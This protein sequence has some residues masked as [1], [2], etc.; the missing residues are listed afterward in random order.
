MELRQTGSEV[1]TK[2]EK[3]QCSDHPTLLCVLLN[4]NFLR[5]VVGRY[6]LPPGL[7]APQ[8]NTQCRSINAPESESYFVHLC[9]KLPPNGPTPVPLSFGIAKKIT[10]EYVI[11]PPVL[12]S[13]QR[14]TKTFTCIRFL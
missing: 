3:A 4:L 7:P 5:L 2:S 6:Y 12:P 14:A 13:R 10:N 9:T 11:P 8:G 1:A